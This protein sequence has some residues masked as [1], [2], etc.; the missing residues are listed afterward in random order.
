MFIQPNGWTGPQ[1]RLSLGPLGSK[2]AD[3][4]VELFVSAR[5]VWPIPSFR[6]CTLEETIGDMIFSQCQRPQ[7]HMFL[8]STCLICDPSV[9][10]PVSETLQV[11]AMLTTDNQLRAGGVSCA[12]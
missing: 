4:A 2:Y 8:F 5:S 3:L 10:N 11:A 6:T 1:P 7:Q 12:S 9:H